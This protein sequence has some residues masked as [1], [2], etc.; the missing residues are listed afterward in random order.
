MTERLH[1]WDHPR[2]MHNTVTDA[3][4]KNKKPKSDALTAEIYFKC[5]AIP[6]QA[7]IMKSRRSVQVEL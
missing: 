7:G 2:L 6:K 5:Y 4:P 1:C 3:L